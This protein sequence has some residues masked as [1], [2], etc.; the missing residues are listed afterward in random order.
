MMSIMMMMT[1]MMMMIIMMMR[2]LFLL[3]STEKRTM[4]ISMK[5]TMNNIENRSS[6]IIYVT[7]E[8]TL[9]EQWWWSGLYLLL[10]HPHSSYLITQEHWAKHVNSKHCTPCGLSRIPGVRRRRPP[11]WKIQP[12]QSVR[13]EDNHADDDDVCIDE[14]DNDEGGDDVEDLW[15]L[16]VITHLIHSLV[17]ILVLVVGVNSHDWQF[18]W[19]VCFPV[20]PRLLPQGGRPGPHRAGK[21][22]ALRWWFW[23]SRRSRFYH[24][25]T[26]G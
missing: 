2:S 22:L 6:S 12:Q 9:M 18:P 4:V 20:P 7:Q 8:R 11:W 16:L 25:N 13:F 5:L 17:M 24:S 21:P 10:E 23:M 1:A 14:D 3:M 19:Q 26:V 15:F